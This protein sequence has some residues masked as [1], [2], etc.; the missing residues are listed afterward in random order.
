MGAM[1]VPTSPRFCPKADAGRCHVVACRSLTNCEVA[2]TKGMQAHSESA[3]C[4]EGI[5][6]V[7]ACTL[8]SRIQTGVVR[9]QSALGAVAFWFRTIAVW[10][11]LG[12]VQAEVEPDALKATGCTRYCCP[13]E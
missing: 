11:L 1:K 6:S 10:N 13:N 5:K 7:S 2:Q 3:T 12:R 9:E 8:P 4:Y